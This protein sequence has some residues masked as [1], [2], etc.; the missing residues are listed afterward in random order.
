MVFG[1]TGGATVELEVRPFNFGQF[2][3]LGTTMGTPREFAALLKVAD[4]GSWMPVMDSVR[5]LA[6]AAAAH[7]SVAPASISNARKEE[8]I[9]RRNR[10]L[11][12]WEGEMER[13]LRQRT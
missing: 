6:E 13:S 8:R 4:Q 1:A 5:P 11:Q 10:A 12:Y 2:S 7:E 3:L 9:W